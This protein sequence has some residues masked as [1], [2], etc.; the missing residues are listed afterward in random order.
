MQIKNLNAKKI[1]NTLT[2]Y[3]NPFTSGPGNNSIG[4]SNKI[5]VSTLKKISNDR[6]SV[7]LGSG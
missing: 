4:Y 5:K 6:I 1:T 7:M 3:G 2:T